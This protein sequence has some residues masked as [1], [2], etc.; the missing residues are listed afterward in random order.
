MNTYTKF[1]YVLKCIEEFNPEFS[2]TGSI[3]SCE[4]DFAES[5]SQSELCEARTHPRHPCLC[6]G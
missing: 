1:L 2:E 4:S 5:D 6:R 3:N